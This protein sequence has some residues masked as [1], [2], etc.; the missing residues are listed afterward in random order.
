ML[1]DWFLHFSSWQ[2][3]KLWW[4]N[5]FLYCLDYNLASLFEF[6]C[7]RRR[8]GDDWLVWERLISL[9]ELSYE[10]N[11]TCSSDGLLT[12]VRKR[13]NLPSC[14]SA[15]SFRGNGNEEWILL[16]VWGVRLSIDSSGVSSSP[17]VDR[18]TQ[19][20]RCRS[21]SSPWWRVAVVLVS[22]PGWLGIQIPEG[23]TPI[24]L[25]TELL[26]VWRAFLAGRHGRWNGPSRCSI[27]PQESV[28][29]VVHRGV[30]LLT[31]VCCF[32]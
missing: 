25:E 14:D 2:H 32:S 10:C 4:E 5:F 27:G 7:R 12:C 26:S 19:E 22:L 23:R 3:L 1:W 30:F 11:K 28:A 9:L 17:E 21:P 18:P 13:V 6:G 16:P 15:E 8:P 31:V 24:L 29:M 20:D